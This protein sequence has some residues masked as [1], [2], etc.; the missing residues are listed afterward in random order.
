[1]GLIAIILWVLTV[2]GFIFW[3]LWQRNSKLEQLAEKQSKF[4]EE[5]KNAVNVVTLMFDKIDEENI[6]RAN[7]FVGQMWLE[8]KSLN[9]QLKNYK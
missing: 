8:L 9:D 6:F 4:I 5:T 1:M 7:D 2:L 3:N